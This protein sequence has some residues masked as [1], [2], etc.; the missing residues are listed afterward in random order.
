MKG[1]FGIEPVAKIGIYHKTSPASCLN[2]LRS[3]RLQM[4]P[5]GGIRPD[6]LEPVEQ[7]DESRVHGLCAGRFLGS[8]TGRS[9]YGDARR[10]ASSCGNGTQDLHHPR[11][12]AA[13]TLRSPDAGRIPA[14]KPFCVSHR[15][16]GNMSRSVRT[17]HMQ[18][19]PYAPASPARTSAQ[20]RTR[21]LLPYKVHASAMQHPYCVCALRR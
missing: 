21:E 12:R 6:Y 17:Y 15:A 14:I 2:R 3:R 8:R 10:N 9:L 13:R 4:V 16:S 19:R 1:R 20:L 11:W 5:V 7:A 18:D